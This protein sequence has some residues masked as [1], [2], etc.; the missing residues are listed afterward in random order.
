MPKQKLEA[1]SQISMRGQQY[2]IAAALSR[3]FKFDASYPP[4]T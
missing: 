2:T 4:Q 1:G 3:R